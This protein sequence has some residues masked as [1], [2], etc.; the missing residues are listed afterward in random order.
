MSAE[1]GFPLVSFS[2]LYEVVG[3]PKIDLGVN[4]SRARSVEKIR[5]EWEWIAILAR[6]AVQTP[7]VNIE[8]QRT[9]LFLYEKDRS[10]TRSVRRADRTRLEV[11]VEILTE[12]SEFGR[13]QGIDGTQWWQFTVFQLYT[14]VV[15]PVFRQSVSAAFAENVGEVM[16]M[17]WN[18]RKV[19]LLIIREFSGT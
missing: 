8:S 15:R 9:V 17:L 11:F 1:S 4:T 14:E 16:V 12:S 2:D 13:G 5:D 19:N 3:V 6:D 7:V 18:I 10:T